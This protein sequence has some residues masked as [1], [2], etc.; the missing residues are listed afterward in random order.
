MRESMCRLCVLVVD[1]KIHPIKDLFAVVWTLSEKTPPFNP[2][3]VC[4]DCTKH[5]T[6]GYQIWY[7]TVPRITLELDNKFHGVVRVIIDLMTISGLC[8]VVCRS[9]PYIGKS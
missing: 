5:L 8:A 4:T 7:R 6:I 3:P 1:F 2:F 9:P